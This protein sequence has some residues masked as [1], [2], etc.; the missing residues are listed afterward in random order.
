[1]KEFLKNL[2]DTGKVSVPATVDSLESTLDVAAIEPLIRQI[3]DEW[4]RRALITAEPMPQLD[5]WLAADAAQLLYR[6]CQLVVCREAS[7]GRI[8]SVI[9]SLPMPNETVDQ[10][11]SVD[12]ILRYLP[13][14][15]RIAKRV[16]MGDPLNDALLQLA[17]DWPLSSVGMPGIAGADPGVIVES[18]VLLALYVDRIIA[19]ADVKRISEGPVKEAVRA[20]IGGFPQLS[21]KVARFVKAKAAARYGQ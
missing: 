1:M 7:P 2:R 14:L 12:V 8:R 3:H 15:G 13:D 5:V 4:A 20:A 11:Y 6:L 17:Q 16:S 9:E 21:P 10:V 18:K 19:T